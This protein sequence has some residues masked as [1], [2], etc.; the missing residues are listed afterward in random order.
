MQLSDSNH[1]RNCLGRKGGV[2][3]DRHF[4]SLRGTCSV[5]KKE[6]P[7]NAKE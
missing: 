6:E 1:V 2:Q 4:L 3:E 7:N 5:T